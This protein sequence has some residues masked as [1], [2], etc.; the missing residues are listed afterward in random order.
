MDSVLDLPAPLAQRRPSGRRA[1][2]VTTPR[3][4]R[5]YCDVYYG[6]GTTPPRTPRAAPPQWA[7]R[8]ATY[9]T[10]RATTYLPP[11]LAQRRPTGRRATL[12]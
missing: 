2:P 8:H 11:R 1:T 7:A 9:V 3:A 6:L 4:H 10:T 5:R 12:Q